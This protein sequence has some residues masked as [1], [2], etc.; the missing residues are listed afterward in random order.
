M[1]K[2]IVDTGDKKYKV[3]A[4]TYDEAIA[5]VKII[6]M[7]DDATQLDIVRA[8]VTDEQAAIAAYTNAIANLDGKVDPQYIEVLRNILKEEN[9]HVE[10]LQA[11]ITGNVTE[12][13]VEDA[14]TDA[15]LAYLYGR[16]RDIKMFIDALDAMR[17]GRKVTGYN[18]ERDIVSEIES[19]L[20]GISSVCKKIQ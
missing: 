15:Q 9:K 2:F 10:N 5:A 17:K 12:K 7:K 1:K 14:A 8:L 13:N 3:N 11:I 18:T 20:E 16:V 6:T 19:M 4:K